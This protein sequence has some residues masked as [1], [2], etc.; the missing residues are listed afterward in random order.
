MIGK[1]VISVT[2]FFSWGIVSNVA[3]AGPFQSILDCKEI[4]EDAK[5]LA[6]FDAAS[7]RMINDRTAGLKVE[8]NRPTKED[9]VASFGK[10][11][12]RSSPVKAVREKEIKQEKNLSHVT[13]TVKKIA[14]TKSKKVVIFMKNGQVWKQKEGG[15]IRL[16]KG[17]FEVEI[18]R[19]A[20]GGYNMTVP[21]KRSFIRVKRLK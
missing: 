2:L 16:P 12:L 9:Q 17:E 18:R 21:N 8:K 4:T 15:K 10:S 19:G 5:R 11:Q 6:C 1:L 3:Q 14:Y 7:Q 13:L 20:I